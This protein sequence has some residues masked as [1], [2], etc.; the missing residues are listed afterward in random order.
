MANNNEM[1]QQQAPGNT[2]EAAKPDIDDGIDHLTDRGHAR[3]C[4]YGDPHYA[5]FAQRVPISRRGEV[6]DGRRGSRS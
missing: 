6:S 5:S 2:S 1:A 3:A 4:P